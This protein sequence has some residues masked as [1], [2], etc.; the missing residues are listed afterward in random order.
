M[1][2]FCLLFNYT[3]YKWLL[4]FHNLGNNFVI[5]IKKILDFFFNKTHWTTFWFTI[6]FNWILPVRKFGPK[7]FVT[8]LIQSNQINMFYRLMLYKISISIY[9]AHN[10]YVLM[11]K[12]HSYLQIGKWI[13]IRVN[14][15][16]E[17]SSHT[18]NK[19]SKKTD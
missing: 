14:Q 8:Q 18:G 7:S 13:S 19:W 2:G 4:L 1:P 10:L 12:I 11:T 6:W 16:E 5:Q 15:I 17:I 9:K 3:T